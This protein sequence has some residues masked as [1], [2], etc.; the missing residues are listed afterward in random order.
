M[1]E[2]YEVFAKYLDNLLP[3]KE[4][5]TVRCPFHDDTHPSFSVN[6]EKGLFKCHACGVEGNLKRFLEL[7]DERFT[8][9]TVAQLV[10]QWHGELLK[11]TRVLKMFIQAKSI[12]LDVIRERRIGYNPNTGRIVI[13]VYNEDGELSGVRYYKPYAEAQKVI[14]HGTMPPCYPMDVLTR[15]TDTIILAE[16]DTDTLAL[17]SAGFNAVMLIPPSAIEKVD[18]ILPYLKK[19][20]VFVLYDDD[21]TG[22]E[23]A[24]RLARRIQQSVTKFV[25][26]IKLPPPVKDVCAFLAENPASALTKILT[27]ARYLSDDEEDIDSLPYVPVSAL[28]STETIGKK[29]ATDFYVCSR[30][31]HRYIVPNDYMVTCSQSHDYCERCAVYQSVPSDGE[32]QGGFFTVEN[33]DI[34][35]FVDNSSDNIY[36]ILRKRLRVPAK[37]NEFRVSPLSRKIVVEATVANRIDETATTD[38]TKQMDFYILQDADSVEANMMY[39]GKVE[40]VQSARTNQLAGIV[41][42]VKPLRYDLSYDIS[43]SLTEFNPREGQTVFEKIMEIAEDLEYITNVN[44]RRETIIAMDLVYHSVLSI[45]FERRRIKGY[46]DTLVI[47]DTRTG[48]SSI[49]KGLVG[50]YRAGEIVDGSNASL[51]GIVGGVTFSNGTAYIAWGLFPRNDGRL[52]VI[53][54]ADEL[55]REILERLSYIRSSGIAEV[56]KIQE[57]RVNARA[58]LIMITNPPSGVKLDDYTYPILAVNDFARSRQDIARFDYVV[59]VKGDVSSI[60]VP[61]RP[62]KHD[63]D[64]YANLVRFA[65]ALAEK[66]IIYTFDMDTL[67][68][69]CDAL[70]KD[71]VSE[72]PL[73]ERNSIYEKLL[74]IATAAAVR[75]FSYNIAEGKLVVGI[76]HLQFAVDFLNTLYGDERNGYRQFSRDIIAESESHDI[77]DIVSALTLLLKPDAVMEKMKYLTTF[78]KNEVFDIVSGS[79]EDFDAFFAMMIRNNLIKRLASGYYTKTAKFTQVMT[80]AL[81][82]VKGG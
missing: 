66:D 20:I 10:D 7:V 33:E 26:L 12:S 23:Y 34:P 63:V 59:V 22:R 3:D 70:A 44:E 76:E 43:P 72:I 17:L 5:Q 56:T 21:K 38:S 31:L 58:R 67:L 27:E 77:N 24:P 1:F 39:R 4:Q 62:L 8:I 6:I 25:K 61:D 55:S 32:M 49:A 64:A 18:A 29:F 73:I 40:M 51:A 19:K 82:R 50:L 68:S 36:R 35:C 15:K 30:T 78:T 54:E 75:T 71:Y 57:G 80:E 81:K 9:N 48:K 37:C 79:R 65:W 13:P 52:V 74:R 53:D 45:R 14:Q 2:Y 47:G 28:T 69:Y 42:L 46:L 41:T 60:K 16:G 11:N